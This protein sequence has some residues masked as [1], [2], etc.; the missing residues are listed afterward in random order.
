LISFG[1]TDAFGKKVASELSDLKWAKTMEVP[2][3]A[4]LLL[5]K[6]I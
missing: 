3:E 1:P 5:K 4:A 6:Q 2:L